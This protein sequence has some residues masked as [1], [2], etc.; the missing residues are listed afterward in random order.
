MI[1]GV[2]ALQGD[3]YAHARCL[4]K[5]GTAWKLIKAPEHLENIDGLILPGGE[6]TAMLKLME[7]RGMLSVLKKFHRS[8]KPMFGTCAGLILL[9]KEVLPAQESLGCIGI[10]VERNAYG[11][12]SDSFIETGASDKNELGT[13][14]IEMVFIRAPKI[15]RLG[16]NVK[17]LAFHGRQPVL[18]RQGNILASTFHPELSEGGSPVHEYF[19]KMVCKK[20]A[21]LNPGQRVVRS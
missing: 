12:Q 4:D 1:I 19:L 15:S 14:K 2:L 17:P 10:S 9:A 7:P 6:S 18:V 20:Q 11:R 8:G 21:S 13:G 3:F 16:K 5:T